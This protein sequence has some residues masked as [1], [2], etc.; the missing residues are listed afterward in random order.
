MEPGRANPLDRRE[1]CRQSRLSARPRPKC[2]LAV[3]VIYAMSAHVARAVF[4]VED[5][6][7]TDGL[8]E[9]WDPQYA[10]QFGAAAQEYGLN[11]TDANLLAFLYAATGDRRYGDAASAALKATASDTV[12][13]APHR[14]LYMY[15]ASGTATATAPLTARS[16]TPTAGNAVH[17]FVHASHL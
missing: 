5:P 15:A 11:R 4:V 2:Y 10:G 7:A 8:T 14:S 17:V 3:A 1:N 16:V 9:P 12:T 6:A 13:A